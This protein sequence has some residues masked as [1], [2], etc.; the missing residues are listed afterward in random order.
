MRKKTKVEFIDIDHHFLFLVYFIHSRQRIRS[1]HFSAM[2]MVEGGM[3][4]VLWLYLTI[5]RKES[6]FPNGLG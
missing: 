3:L 4:D 5:A 2:S 1:K 6:S